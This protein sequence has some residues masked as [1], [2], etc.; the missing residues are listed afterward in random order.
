MKSSHFLAFAAILGLSGAASAAWTRLPYAQAEPI[1]L[2]AKSIPGTKVV[3]S[4]GVENAEA[5]LSADPAAA[6]HVAAGKSEVTLQLRGQPI[7]NVVDFVNDG[8]EGKV[9]IAGSPDEKNWT[10]LARSVFGAGD[11]S[12]PVTFAG[13]Q[14]K[15]LSISF[16]SAQGGTIRSLGVYG[17]AT[18]RDFVLKKTGSD[19][20]TNLTA[21]AG[22]AHAIYA[23]PTP[24]S[25]GEL[26]PAYGI[27][28]FPNSADKYR[29]IVYDL[30]APRTIRE[31]S[32]AYSQQSVHLD[33]FAFETLP[34]K[35]DWRGKLTLDPVIFNDSP[36]VASGDDAR[37]VGHIR[38]VPS[39]PIVAQ[40][41]A[42][43]FEVGAAHV[44]NGQAPW[45]GIAQLGLDSAAS[46]LNAFNIVPQEHLTADGDGSFTVYSC[47][48][49]GSGYSDQTSGGGNGTGDDGSPPGQ[50]ATNSATGSTDTTGPP[51]YLPRTPGSPP[52]GSGGLPGSG[53][54]TGT[55]G[56]IQNT[57]INH[58]DHLG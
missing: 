48:V 39:K 14:A 27:F 23:F 43:R 34:E 30:G 40:F 46:L 31:F 15:Y 32:A 11:R 28:K 55:G 3:A 33:V 50:P 58:C 12:V 6:T 52:A 56:P 21:G 5:L 24:S 47:N 16:E 44:S 19:A 29:T 13:A 38:I 53:A 8:V 57:T 20:N 7:V 37:G 1:N 2:A 49:G 18:G 9:T 36:P 42:L 22:G 17:S 54:G 25:A 4:K 10:P 35:K 45:T 26:G 51:P 41:V